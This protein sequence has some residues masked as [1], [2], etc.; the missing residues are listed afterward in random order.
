MK[1]SD[2]VKARLR[3][4]KKIYDASKEREWLKSFQENLNKGSNRKY[5]VPIF[6][7]LNQKSAE[8]EFFWDALHLWFKRRNPKFDLN[9]D[10]KA[11]INSKALKR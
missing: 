4:L 6:H 8:S 9:E 11:I 7:L 2:E 1:Y 10:P 5:L 3:D